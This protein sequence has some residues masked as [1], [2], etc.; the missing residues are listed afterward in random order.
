[1]GR[2]ASALGNPDVTALLDAVSVT[3]ACTAPSTSHA[4]HYGDF[5]FDGLIG[6]TSS[7]RPVDLHDALGEVDAMQECLQ[8]DAHG[9]PSESASPELLDWNV[10]H[11][12]VPDQ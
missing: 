5:G 11:D 2:D 12:C 7:G 4:V 6:S 10:L 3:V 9:T 8:M 1:V